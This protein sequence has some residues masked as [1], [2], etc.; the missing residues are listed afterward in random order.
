MYCN[1][2]CNDN[3]GLGMMEWMLGFAGRGGNRVSDLLAGAMVTAS[4]FAGTIVLGRRLRLF[5][6]ELAT[7][8][9]G[10]KPPI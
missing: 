5:D 8:G 9:P 1:S 7:T 6:P 3:I 2:Q 4:T 10:S